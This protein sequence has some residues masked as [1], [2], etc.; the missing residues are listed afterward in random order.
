[1]LESVEST[2]LKGDGDRVRVAIVHDFL[3]CYG[4]AER[5]L[6]EILRVFPSADLFSLFDFLPE[7]ERGFIRNK[8]VTTSFIQNLPRARKNHRYYLPL[9]P[10]A[11][12][13][14]DVTDYDLVISSSYLAAKGVI[15]RPDQLHV[16]YCHSPIRAAWDLQHQYLEQSGLTK[17]VKSSLTRMIL[18][19]IRMWDVRSANSVDQF[20]TNSKYIARR[21]KTVY[22]RESEV[23]YPPVDIDRFNLCTEKDDYYVTVSRLVPY[24][25]IDL[26]VKAFAEMP[27]RR[28]IV[29]GDGP[30]LEAI[31]ALGRGH[32]NIEIRGFVES[33]EVVRT[34]QRARAFVFA[35]EEDFG[36]V[37]VEAQACGTPVIA[38]GRGGGTESVIDQ[39]TGLFFARQSEEAVRDA[40]H[41]FESHEGGWDPEVIRHNA[42]RFGSK[43][44]CREFKELVGYV[45]DAFHDEEPSICRLELF[46]E[47]KEGAKEG[48]GQGGD[49]DGDEGRLSLRG[50]EE[51]DAL[52]SDGDGVDRSA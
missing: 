5:V 33:D 17:G 3:Y 36:I 34:M 4:G 49:R 37:P 1:M 40:V 7:D 9:M 30:D 10:L 19:Y 35:A 45:W 22:R 43:R 6:E 51:L 26:I 52:E 47:E 44:F 50:V 24:K 46:P 8:P 15:T 2:M 23:I 31:R 28:L 38:Y 16:C 25:R 21:V 20:I 27:E 14:M 11:I 18:H 48:D 29:I 12:E 42:E 32:Q 41:R 39:E 13:Q